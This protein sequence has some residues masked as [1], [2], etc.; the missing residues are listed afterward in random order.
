[1]SNKNSM[2]AHKERLEQYKH[3][4]H[5]DW[6]KG[7]AKFRIPWTLQTPPISLDAK[8]K[9]SIESSVLKKAKLS[10]SP[11]PSLKP[12]KSKFNAHSKLDPWTVSR[13]LTRMKKKKHWKKLIYCS[14]KS[15]KENEKKTGMLKITLQ[16]RSKVRLLKLRT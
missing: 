4:I 10:T 1:M 2:D 7:E 15:I 6:G 3:L 16:Q 12:M 11:D 5:L 14:P 13:L 8:S 9:K